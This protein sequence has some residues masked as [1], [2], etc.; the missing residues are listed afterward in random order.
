MNSLLSVI[1]FVFI[2][3][4][5]IFIIV[6]IT[7]KYFRF[8]DKYGF[9]IK[10]YLFLSGIMG[11]IY[12]I[13]VKYNN[14]DWDLWA[15]LAVG[16]IFSQIGNV[17]PHDIFAYTPTKQFWVDH[18]WGAGAVFYYLVHHFGDSGLLIFKFMILFG[19]FLFVFY[20]NQH[21]NN[22]NDPYRISYYMLLFLAILPA[23]NGIIRSHVFTYF[24]FAL[25]LYTLD[26]VRKGKNKFI[27][28][29]PVT[30]V[31]WANTHGGFLAGLGIIAL[32]AIGEFINK[33]NP[34]KYL[35]ILVLSGAATLI[36]PY[37]LKYWSFL[38]SAVTMKRPYVNEWAPLN[39]FESAT[40]VPGF[41]IFAVLTL[42]SLIYMF[43]KRFKRIN[44]SDV[45]IL[46]VTFYMSLK[47]I[48]HIIFFSI[49]AAS[50]IYYWL[51]PAINW[52]TFNFKERLYSLFPDLLRKFGK[53]YRET[54]IYNII[55]LFSFLSIV[56]LPYKIAVKDYMFPTKAVKFI[57]IN[58]LSGNLL[59]LFNWG[60]YALWKLYPQ[61]HIAVDGRYEEVY[62]DDFIGDVARFHYT[63]KNWDGLLTKYPADLMLIPIE[64]KELYNKLQM[65]DDWKI[66]YKDKMAAVF[67]PKALNKKWI[68][69]P[70]N[71]NAENEKYISDIKAQ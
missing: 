5:L 22:E 25:W 66:V 26:L 62:P 2:T 36:N 68:M 40:Q 71:F 19:I 15:R 29:F 57:Q 41:K 1:A 24:F 17:L 69:P 53:I 23:F 70:K 47:H 13:T 61:C 12:Y 7:D 38:I 49:A 8:L 51:Y 18:E 37:G 56:S 10:K 14:F 54:L 46:A 63:G 50:Y 60:S 65:L 45:L 34:L 16:K 43:V 4:T 28:L 11:I 55:F 35:L 42:L 58:H 30:M 59:V 9:K 3:V 52:Y 21:R 44:W 48:R 39:F 20:T 32:F 6:L 33:R 31:I 67:V 27:W 64:Y